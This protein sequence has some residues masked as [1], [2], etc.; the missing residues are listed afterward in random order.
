MVRFGPKLE[1]KQAFLFRAV[2]VALELFALSATI[3]RAAG[4]AKRR[5]RATELADQLA[6]SARRRISD[7]LRDMWRNHDAQRYHLARGVSQGRFVWLE[8]GTMGVPF[9]ESELEPERMQDFFDAREREREQSREPD[10]QEDS[11]A[12]RA[13]GAR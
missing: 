11:R 8:E 13:A 3:A 9:S 12:A 10:Y 6:W 7:L 2:D 5:E 4:E 1:R